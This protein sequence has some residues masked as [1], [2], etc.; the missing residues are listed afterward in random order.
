MNPFD[1]QL[2]WSMSLAAARR[3]ARSPFG[4]SRPE[5][6]PLYALTAYGHR[7]ISHKL[8]G[9][10]SLD[11]LD[12]RL[13]AALLART[14]VVASHNPVLAPLVER[15]LVER[16]PYAPLDAIR[17]R[18]ARNPLEHVRRV[19]FE[20][21][22]LCNLDCAH[23]RNSH[24]EATHTRDASALAR[25]GEVWIAAGVTRFD[26]IGGEVIAYAKGWLE[27]VSSL[28]ARGATH[29]SVLTSGWFLGAGGFVAA[30]R[31]YENDD[32]LLSDLARSGVTHVVFSLDGPE[33]IHDRS[34]ASA[35]LYR[36]ALASFEKV[37]AHGLHPRVSVVVDRSLGA[38]RLAAWLDSLA[39][40]V[41]LDPSARGDRLVA[42]E[43]NYAS[44]LVDVGG[45][46]QLRRS[47]SAPRGPGAQ[48]SD[49]QL[50]CKNFFRPSPTF[51]V[52]ASGEV[53]LCPLVDGGD[54]YG[55]VFDRD[56][57][58]ILNHMHEALVFRL[59]ADREIAR[60]R[61]LLDRE[62]FAGQLEH[63]CS[64]RTALNMLAAI[65]ERRRVAHDDRAALRE[66]NREVAERM[67][68]LPRVVQHR[69][70]G[71]ALHVERPPTG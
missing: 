45:A 2:G 43:S 36:R 56:I 19:V 26:F 61:P 34:R 8:R 46:V 11:S 17:T 59:H 44:N 41:Y 40:A 16:V 47:K 35:G 4:P 67:G 28:V 29:V 21:T 51:R 68:I 48:F 66:A 50:R 14:A 49:E 5:R 31:R 10:S 23:C 42:D 27:L 6:P 63:L 25:V 58:W 15:S 30:G 64:L 57:L 22:T 33:E 55:N 7:W 65:I 52:K 13:C 12:E 3:R 32:E 53:S 38:E 1:P 39:R 18:Y 9:G 71:H 20:Y 69:A 60:Y 37:R 70:N 62:L 24:L 54:G